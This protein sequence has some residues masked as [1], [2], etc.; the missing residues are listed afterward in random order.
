MIY[1][2]IRFTFAVYK[3]LRISRIY[4]LFKDKIKCF[5][6]STSNGYIRQGELLEIVQFLHRI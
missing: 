2:Y 4:F 6:Y 1:I 3:H 5:H